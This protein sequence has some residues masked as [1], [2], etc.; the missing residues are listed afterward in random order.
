MKHLVFVVLMVLSASRLLAGYEI[1]ICDSVNKK[2]QCEGKSDLFHYTGDR[3]M[4][5]ALV[6]NKDMLGTP[7]I[8]FKLYEMANDHDGDISAELS[9][10]VKPGWFA[11][12]KRLYFFKPGYY[13]LEVFNAKKALLG[14]RFITISDR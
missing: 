11:V 5:Q 4:L 9:T 14:T 12:V 8:Y 10:E 13:K 3:M 6:Y 2:G 7:K 1:S